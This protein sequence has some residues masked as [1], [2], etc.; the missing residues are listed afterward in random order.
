MEDYKERLKKEYLDL[1]QKI[2]R[3]ECGLKYD[4]IPFEVVSKE[5]FEAQ[6]KAM[7][8]Y[9][10]ILGQRITLEQIEL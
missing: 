5:I 3:L 1:G 2:N 10:D 9:F 8:K 4:R 7:K 6:L